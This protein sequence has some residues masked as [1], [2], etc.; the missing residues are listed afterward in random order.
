MHARIKVQNLHISRWTITEKEQLTKIN[1]GFEENPQQVKINVNLEPIISYQLID[2][3]KEFKD[4]F[5]W[6]Y[7]NL[8]GIRP[9]IAQHWIE[10]DTLIP[11]VHQTRYQLNPNYVAIVKQDIDKFFAT[12]FIK[13]VEEV[14][15]LSPI[16]VMLEKNGKLKTRVDF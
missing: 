3:L 13:H 5:A 11:H 8:K 15:W 16:I 14:T 12:S 4:I 7:K 2:L 6:T 1:L 9:D 10:L